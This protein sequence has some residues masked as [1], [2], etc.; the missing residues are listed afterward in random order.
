MAVASAA[1]ALD[2]PGQS[3][4]VS[5]SFS[6]SFFRFL[7]PFFL[8]RVYLYQFKLILGWLEDDETPVA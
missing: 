3:V 8:P 7:S 1:M 6:F 4:S 5:L 2:D